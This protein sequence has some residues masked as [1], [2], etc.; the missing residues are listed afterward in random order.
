VCVLVEEIGGS[1]AGTTTE[2][3]IEAV[4]E[5]MGDDLFVTPSR[6]LLDRVRSPRRV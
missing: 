1:R 4:D 6:G 3:V 5:E 2:L